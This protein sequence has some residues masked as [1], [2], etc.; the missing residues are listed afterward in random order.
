MRQ[1]LPAEPTKQHSLPLPHTSLIQ[2][3]AS[4]KVLHKTLF[5]HWCGW[6]GTPAVFM[7]FLFFIF[8]NTFL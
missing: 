2:V 3:S 1:F 7:F 5:G 4:I 8:K 6:E